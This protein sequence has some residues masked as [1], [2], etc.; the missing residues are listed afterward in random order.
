MYVLYNTAE[1]K[2]H[3]HS[4]G[5]TTLIG[6]AKVYRRLPKTELPK[7]WVFKEVVL[8]RKEVIDS[9][10]KAIRDQFRYCIST[11]ARR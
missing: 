4:K 9:V 2:Y 7:D 10:R 1:Q 5:Y 3:H 6:H 11:V 8:E